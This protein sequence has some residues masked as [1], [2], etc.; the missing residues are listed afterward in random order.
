MPFSSLAFI[1]LSI[2]VTVTPYPSVPPP[3]DLNVDDPASGD[4]ASPP[5]SVSFPHRAPKPDP[6][7]N[8]PAQCDGQAP[9]DDCFRALAY[10]GELRYDRDSECS[11]LQKDTLQ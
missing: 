10:G 5:K 4:P 8:Q 3:P 1:L 9:S 11:D 2:L 6:I 7:T